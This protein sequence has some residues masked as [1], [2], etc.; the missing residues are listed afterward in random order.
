VSVV[1]ICVGLI[2]HPEESNRVSAFDRKT[3]IM[4]RPWPTRGYCTIG[5]PTVRIKFNVF[6]GKKPYGL[7]SGC[8]CFA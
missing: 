4:R 1:S 6:W 8:H 3:S 5:G 2:T 7:V